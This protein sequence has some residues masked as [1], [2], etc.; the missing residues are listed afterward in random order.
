MRRFLVL[1]I[2][3][4]L[5]VASPA[6]AEV[7]WFHSPSRNISCEVSSGGE[8]GASAFCQSLQEPQSVTLSEQGT[9]KVCHGTKCLGDGPEGAFELGY[10]KSIKVGNF[11]CTSKKAGMRCSHFPS[12][13]G[14][15]LS[16]HAVDRF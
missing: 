12:G 2:A 7:T 13:R 16:R 14:F 9:M 4:T 1:S 6:L 11:K 5:T 3:L 8:R 15:E 10:G